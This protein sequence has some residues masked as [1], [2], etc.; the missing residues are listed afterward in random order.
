MRDISYIIIYAYLLYT[1]NGD[2]LTMDRQSEIKRW[3]DG[4]DRRPI[5]HLSIG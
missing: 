3:D 4:H 2:R 1:T 5:S